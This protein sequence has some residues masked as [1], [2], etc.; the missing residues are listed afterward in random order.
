[1]RHG[2]AE[3]RNRAD[4]QPDL[5]GHYLQHIADVPLLTAAEEVQLSFDI[6]AGLLAEDAL[7]NCSDPGLADDLRVLVRLGVRARWRMVSSNL[8]LVVA[9]TRY[10]RDRGVPLLDLIQEGNLG[11]LR[12]VE[13]FDYRRGIK[14]STYAMWWIRQSIVRGVADGAR[15]VRLPVHVITRLDACL[16]ARQELERILARAPTVAEIA[17]FSGLDEPVVEQLLRHDNRF[18]ALGSD[19]GLVGQMVGDPA[20]D[21]PSERAAAAVMSDRLRDALACLTPLE[22]EVVR[23]RYGFGA[24][25]PSGARAVGIELGLSRDRVRNIEA[26]ALRRIRRTTAAAALRGFLSA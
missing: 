5:L 26:R 3:S 13:K 10:Y 6:E 2:A 1:M 17:G 9:A 14:F 7:G 24:R 4:H 15:S 21:D 18:V 19:A 23:R 20:A 8:R 22:L 16:G 12:A 25:P 11:L